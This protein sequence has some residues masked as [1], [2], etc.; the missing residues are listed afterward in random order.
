[1]S[2]ISFA[3]P[4]EIDVRGGSGP[5]IQGNHLIALVLEPD[6]IRI[7]PSRFHSRP[8][9]RTREGILRV[10]ING[11]ETLFPY[12]GSGEVFPK[13]RDKL[14]YLGAAPP[15]LAFDLNLVDFDDEEREALGSA[16]GVLEF[17]G[18]TALGTLA[19]AVFAGFALGGSLLRFVQSRLDDE[20]EAQ[21]FVVHPRPL[22]FDQTLSLELR[23]QGTE[24]ARL[25]LAMRVLDLGP[26]DAPARLR[27]RVGNPVLALEPPPGVRARGGTKQASPQPSWPRTGLHLFNFEARSRTAAAAYTTKFKRIDKVLSWH[28]R[29]VFEAAGGVGRDRHVLPL[30]MGF[31]LNEKDLHA[32]ALLAV[33]KSTL[34][35]AHAVEP[36]VERVPD[37]LKKH[38]ATTLSFLSEFT[39]RNLLLFGFDGVLVLGDTQSGGVPDGEGRLVLPRVEPGTW[40]RRIERDVTWRGQPVGS[41]A[42]DLEAKRAE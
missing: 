12:T 40:A 25:R 41:F 18:H 24:G 30:T 35:L 9:G 28:L 11:Q 13:F 31:S 15:D 21:V 17:V 32:E 37:L 33:A 10:R 36:K 19:P 8:S 6:G 1:M 27:I 4:V 5:E 23:S 26:V 16:A 2:D 14:L 3:A 42:F 29:D 39:P 20:E 38:G 34:A 22:E 7:D